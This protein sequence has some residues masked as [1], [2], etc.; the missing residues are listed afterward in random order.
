MGPS[1]SPRTL[2]ERDRELEAIAR[3]CADVVRAA[4]RA[5]SVRGGSGVGKSELIARGAR[6]ARERGMLVAQARAGE[7]ERAWGFGLARQLLE[8][9]L[10]ESG[11]PDLVLSGAG[12]IAS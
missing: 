11:Q 3:L 10:R 4:G 8:S 7:I 2:F 9:L 1:E 5:L 12:G 6:A